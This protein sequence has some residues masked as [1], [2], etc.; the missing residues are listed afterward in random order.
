MNM[1]IGLFLD[2]LG[3][4]KMDFSRPYDG[5]PGIGGTEYMYLM[6]GYYMKKLYPD[7]GITFFHFNSN[8]LP[9]RCGSV[10]ISDELDIFS[11]CKKRNINVVIHHTEK[12]REWYRAAYKKGVSLIVWAECYLNYPEISY[13]THFENVKR[14]VFVSRQEYDRYIDD[15]VIEKSTYIYNMYASRPFRRIHASKKENIVTFMG[16]LSE[17][18]GFHILAKHW[19]EVLG[20]VPDAQLMVIGSGQLYSR[21]NKLG[22][23]QI[24][25]ESYEKQ[26]MNYLTDEQGEILSSVHFKGIV[27]EEKDELLMKSKAGVVNPT[28]VSETFCISAVEMEA[29]GLPV[30]TKQE[31]GLCDTV[32]NGFTG[33]TFRKEEKIS[34]CIVRL[35]LD[36]SLND[37]C[38]SNGIRFVKKMFSPEKIT[39]QWFEL[40]QSID[41]LPA[42]RRPSDCFYNDYKWLRMINRQLRKIPVLRKTGS[43]EWKRYKRYERIVRKRLER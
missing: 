23:Y 39:A 4:Q 13:I 11:E 24:A 27:G 43:I 42:Y 1:N 40:L 35:L 18:K 38:S 12:S 31:F 8:H 41:E 29:V 28:A 25:E 7:I 30:V 2:D 20:K 32:K 10:I 14:V 17:T 3:F 21:N 16:N 9:D 15:P 22:P 26:F 36:D 34:K 19:R 5:N 37:R 6:L 33:L